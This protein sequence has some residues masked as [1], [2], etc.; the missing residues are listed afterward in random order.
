MMVY[1]ISGSK[2][3]LALSSQKPKQPPTGFQGEIKSQSR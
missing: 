3:L 1:L 2:T